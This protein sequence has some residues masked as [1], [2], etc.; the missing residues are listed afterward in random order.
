MSTF[1]N[2]VIAITGAASGMGLAT[3]QLLASRGALVSLA[4]VNAQTLASALQ[5]LEQPDRHLLTTLDVRDGQQVRMWI[6]STV[7]RFGRLDGAV[8]MAGVITKA[9]PTIEVTD[10]DW[11]LTFAVNVKGV[12]NCLRSELKAMSRGGSI[13]SQSSLSL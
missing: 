5:T 11:D 7:T 1:H 9:M 10:E 12:L 6:E 13:V 8:N 3:A 4:D 2:R